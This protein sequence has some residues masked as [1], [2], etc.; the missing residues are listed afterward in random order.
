MKRQQ[1]LVYAQAGVS[2]L[3]LLCVAN[4]S[5][6]DS[7]TNQLLSELLEQHTPGIIHQQANNPW[8]GGNYTLKVLKNG[9]PTVH[10]DSGSIHFQMPLKIDISGDA[11]S[12]FLRVH[13]ACKAS[14]TT[15]G[16]VRFAPLKPGDVT[17]L[18][19]DVRVS[20]PPV[21]ADCDGVQLPIETYVKALVQQ[22]KPDWEAQI[23]AEVNAW[24]AKTNP[25]S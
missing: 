19:S 15:L 10:S 17:V 24:L 2:L 6:A 20:V 1:T 11:S 9:R 5:A 14:F 22:K 7:L 13:L 25:S 23:D 4:V 3:G 18:K 8:P 21:M 16:E 12:S